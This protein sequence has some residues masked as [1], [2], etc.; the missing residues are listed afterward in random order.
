[1]TFRIYTLFFF[2]KKVSFSC[3]FGQFRLS[4]AILSL[5]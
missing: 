3:I 1:M 4:K 2:F 5:R